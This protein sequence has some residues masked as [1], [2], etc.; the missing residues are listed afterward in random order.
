MLVS[1]ALPHISD[2]VSLAHGNGIVAERN[3]VRKQQKELLDTGS[4]KVA[5]RG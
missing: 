2:P 5:V 4:R 1:T 3:S